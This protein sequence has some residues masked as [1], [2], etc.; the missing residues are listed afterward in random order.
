MLS[1]TMSTDKP[2]R[3]EKVATVPLARLL[4]RRPLPEVTRRM[5]V[6]FPELWLRYELLASTDAPREPRRTLTKRRPVGSG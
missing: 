2:R 5:R 6:A 1:L 3:T 4:G